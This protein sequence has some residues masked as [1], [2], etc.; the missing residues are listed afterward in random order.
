M[1]IL[2][3]C[4]R[5]LPYDIP[6]SFVEDFPSRYVE[7]W[8]ELEDKGW[9]WWKGKGLVAWYYVRPNCNTSPPNTNGINFFCSE[10]DYGGESMC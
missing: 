7:L 4:D 6:V 2:S 8:K 9:Y 3:F 10:D 5:I 1:D